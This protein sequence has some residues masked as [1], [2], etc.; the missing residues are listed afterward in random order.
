MISSLAVSH[1]LYSVLTN[2]QSI[3]IDSLLKVTT[4]CAIIDRNNTDSCSK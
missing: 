2:Y 1:P 3:I 4:D